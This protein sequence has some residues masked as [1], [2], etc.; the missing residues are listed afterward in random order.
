MNALPMANHLIFQFPESGQCT[1]KTKITNLLGHTLY[2]FA[3]IPIEMPQPSALKAARLT[4][5]IM[6]GIFGIR[7]TFE[8]PHI[9]H[10]QRFATRWIPHCLLQGGFVNEQPSLLHSHGNNA[11]NRQCLAFLTQF[12]RFSNFIKTILH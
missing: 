7:Q 6:E 3:Q 12:Q 4:Q 2:A 11:D 1:Q 9:R 10:G 5:Q 8:L